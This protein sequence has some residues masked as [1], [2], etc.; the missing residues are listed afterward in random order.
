[1]LYNC[2]RLLFLARGDPW[3]PGNHHHW[4]NTFKNAARTLLLVA[5]RCVGGA[6]SGAAAD[7]A[8]KHPSPAGGGCFCL[9]ALPAN[10]V[11]EVISQ[12]ASP[13]AAWL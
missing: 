13:I 8:P 12:A 5:N 4:P 11:L 6:G 9:A 1:M 2:C 3:S 10:A 7:G